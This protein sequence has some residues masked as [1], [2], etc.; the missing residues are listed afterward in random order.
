MKSSQD[1]ESAWNFVKWLL[2]TETQS[3]YGRD[4]E[5]VVG[6][7]ARY[8]TAN[9]EAMNLVKWDAD[10]KQQLEKQR[11]Q[12]KAYPQIAGGYITD[13]EF[14]FA[15]RKIIYDDESVRESMNEATKNI[16]YEIIRKREEFGLK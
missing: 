7:A 1:T 6:T 4:L 10:I 15:F 3:A 9:V 5:S 14:N 8:N 2:S 13:R 12:I 11:V 16:N